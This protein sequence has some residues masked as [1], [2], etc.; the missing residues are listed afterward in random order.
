MSLPRVMNQKAAKKLLQDHGWSEA[1]GGKH[2]VKMTKPGH[3][4]I[5]L[6][7]HGGE[8]YS[9]RLTAAIL[10]QAGLR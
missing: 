3:R 6:P 8:D 7:H 1:Q 4:P 10:K 2:G 5:P 9:K